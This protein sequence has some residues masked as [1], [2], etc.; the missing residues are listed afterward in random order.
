MRVRLRAGLLGPVQQRGSGTDQVTKHHGELAT[1]GVSGTCGSRWGDGISEGMVC[2][3]RRR[4]HGLMRGGRWQWR[5][6]SGAGPHQHGAILINGTLVDL[7][8]FHLEIVKVRVIKVKLALERPV[9]DAAALAEQRKDLI[10]H[11]VKV[12]D[13][14]SPCLSGSD[15]TASA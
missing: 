14:L 7:D 13:R 9:G 11:R 1:L 3:R 2:L 15:R 4:V 8:E 10:Q 12:H 6:L 5:R